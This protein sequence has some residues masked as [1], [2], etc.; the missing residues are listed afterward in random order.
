MKALP[1]VTV[2]MPI[3]NEAEFIDRSLGA[4]L[5]QEYPASAVEIL[6]AYGRSTDGTRQR[7]ESI[8]ERHAN[9]RLIDNPGRIVSTGMNAAL[10]EA[11]GEVIV[12]VDGHCEIAPDYLRN[13]VRHL[14]EE[15]VDG[16]GGPLDTVGETATARAI[17]AAM[18][19][20]FGVGGAAFRTGRSGDRRVD[21]VAFPAYTRQAVMRAGAFDEELVRN[22]DDEYNY[23]LRKLDGR[24]RLAADMRA[25]YYSRSTFRSLWRQYFQY[26]FWKVRVL[27]KH[28]RQMQARQF[29]PPLFV[30]ALA[31]TACAAPAIAPARMLLAAV[32][33]SYLV[34]NLLGAGWTARRHGWRHLLRLP[35]AFAFLHLSYGMGFLV[36]LARF[37]HRFQDRRGRVPELAMPPVH[38]LEDARASDVPPQSGGLS[39]AP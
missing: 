33:G 7:L 34:A 16:V 18:S 26:G 2:I 21:T 15:G 14:L 19:S 9:L 24:I 8:R 38:G 4:V 25:R 30:L 3:R 17:A 22:Q 11:R 10:A 39:S 12:R 13:G 37:A 23:R 29:V 28:P 35:I 32:A 5:A 27:Q 31:A 1:L 6:V 36:G 20:G